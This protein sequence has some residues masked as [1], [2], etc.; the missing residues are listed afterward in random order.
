MT[1]R[2]SMDI[3]AL[4]GTLD[5]P[6]P[7]DG[8]SAALLALWHLGRKDWAAA[9]AVVQDADD[10][11]SAWVHAHLHRVEGDLA[12][13][14]YWYRRARRPDS[15]DSLDAEWQGIVRALLSADSRD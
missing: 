7:P 12:N 14:R 13:A 2:Y 11:D 6:A 1:Q 9:H 15:T 8:L 10:G 4:R 5:D 3:D